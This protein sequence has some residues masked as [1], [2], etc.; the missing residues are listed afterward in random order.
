MSVQCILLR[1]SIPVY[2]LEN[3]RHTCGWTWL[4]YIDQGDRERRRSTSSGDY[5]L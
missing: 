4:D 1:A 2:T 5:N 3:N